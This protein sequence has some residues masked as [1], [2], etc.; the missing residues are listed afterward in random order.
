MAYYIKSLNLGID[1]NQVVIK[2]WLFLYCSSS[3]FVIVNRILQII[4][5]KDHDSG[6]SKI[7][8][9]SFVVYLDRTF[10]FFI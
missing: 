7:L 4:T 6:H 9:K 3:S 8:N 10:G 5:A 1:K 2:E